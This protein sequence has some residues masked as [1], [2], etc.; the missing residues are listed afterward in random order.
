[1]ARKTD[2]MAVVSL[3]CGVASFV[4]FP[5]L[6]AI[7]AII[8]G[9]MSRDRI[10]KSAGNLDGEGLAITGLILGIINVALIAAVFILILV[11]ALA[12][13]T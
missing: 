4:I 6:P 13:S 7:A 1:M 3:I 8:L 9:I 12:G 5:L 2:E 11:I 10:R